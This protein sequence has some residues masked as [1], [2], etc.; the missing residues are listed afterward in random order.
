MNIEEKIP[1]SV[2]DC[3]LALEKEGYKAFVVGGAIRDLIMGI[4]PHDFDL[5]TSATYEETSIV[6]KNKGVFSKNFKHDTVNVHYPDMDIEITSFRGDDRS[7]IESDLKKRDFTVDSLAYSLNDGLIDV[8]DSRK[9]IEDKIIRSSYDPYQDFKDD[10]L[11][12]L[13]GLRLACKFDFKIEKKTEQAMI[14]ES[15]L[16]NTVSPERIGDEFLKIIVLKNSD[17]IIRDYFDIFTAFLPELLPMKD[18][19]QHSPY[20]VFDVLE[21]S[22]HVLKYIKDRKPALCLAALFHDIAKPKTFFMKDKIGHFYGHDEEGERITRPI[23]SRLKYSNSLIDECLLLIRW[24]MVQ[25]DKKKTV[26]RMMTRLGKDIFYELIELREADIKGCGREDP[27]YID[28]L[29]NMY[30]EIINNK[31]CFSLKDLKI[32]GR[33]LLELGMKPSKEMGKVLNSLL[34]MVEDDEIEN[35]KDVLIEEAKKKIKEL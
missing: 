18:F 7:S 15:S 32:G 20:H 23:L 27:P 35:D 25:M 17:E 22:L 5:A 13:R 30:F 14:K 8:C 24:H 2:K 26:K 19:N 9:D 6:F 34:V 16:I 28:N 1:D 31:E 12:I 4:T 33:D 11:R 29:R 3:L 10:S 21:H